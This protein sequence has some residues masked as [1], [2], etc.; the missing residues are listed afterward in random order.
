VRSKNVVLTTTLIAAASISSGCSRTEQKR[1]VSGDGVVV[2]DEECERPHRTGS[3]MLGAA[4][5]YRWY[6]GGRGGTTPGSFV[7]GGGYQPVP[8]KTYATPSQI[9][10]GG[11]GSSASHAGG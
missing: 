9:S 11:F 5:M 7:S 8:G 2:R 1:C 3:S 10:R 6:Y 4:M